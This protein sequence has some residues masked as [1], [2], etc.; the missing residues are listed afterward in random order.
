M[1]HIFPNNNLFSISLMSFIAF[2]IVELTIRIFNLYKILPI[3]DIIAHIF[4]GIAMALIILWL[5]SIAKYTKLE[6]LAFFWTVVGTFIWEAL[7]E[8]EDLLFYNPPHLVDFFIWD[9]VV[10]VII[11]ILAGGVTLLIVKK[12]NKTHKKILY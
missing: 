9:V 10:D 1:K 8:L 3:V 4:A 7:E 2:L 6:L 5:L 11:T 12:Y